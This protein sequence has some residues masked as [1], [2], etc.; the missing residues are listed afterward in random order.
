MLPSSFRHHCCK[1]QVAI[2]DANY[3]ANIGILWSSFITWTA[4]RC[5]P[6]RIYLGICIMRCVMCLVMLQKA[7]SPI[8]S[9]TTNQ[10]RSWQL[11]ISEQHGTATQIHTYLHDL[12][13]GKRD[14]YHPENWLL[15]WQSNDNWWSLRTPWFWET[16]YS[17]NNMGHVCHNGHCPT[18]QGVVGTQV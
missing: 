17:Y 10:Q 11:N 14:D 5:N 16:W 18:L 2:V 9:T 8:P 4:V 7:T 12:L 6:R 15:V 13:P 1:L 3:M